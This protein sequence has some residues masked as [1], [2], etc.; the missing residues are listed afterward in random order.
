M[1]F[2]ESAHPR[3]ASGRFTPALR[4][5]SPVILEGVDKEALTAGIESFLEENGSHPAFACVNSFALRRALDTAAASIL[6]NSRFVA[7]PPA[8]LIVRKSAGYLA[9]YKESAFTPPPTP[10]MLPWHAP[11][12][13]PVARMSP[14]G[15]IEI[16][17]EQPD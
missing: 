3:A 11:S 4:P 17:A 2:D 15:T 5:E 8:A 12:G 7:Q 9:V 1:A 16:L 13:E 10:G 14:D 6:D